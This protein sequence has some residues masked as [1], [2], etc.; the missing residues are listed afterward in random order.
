MYSV[1]LFDYEHTCQDFVTCYNSFVLLYIVLLYGLYMSFN[2][3]IFEWKNKSNQKSLF[4]LL[5]LVLPSLAIQDVSRAVLTYGF[6][7]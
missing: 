4:G 3:W 7:L 2:L 6:I 1:N 5:T